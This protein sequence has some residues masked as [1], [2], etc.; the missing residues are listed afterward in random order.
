M[1][2]STAAD[3]EKEVNSRPLKTYY[4]IQDDK[5][6]N[7]Y[8]ISHVIYINSHC[9]WEEYEGTKFNGRP[10]WLVIYASGNTN[11]RVWE[12]RHSPP[13]GPSVVVT[14]FSEVRMKNFKISFIFLEPRA[15]FRKFSAGWL[16]L[17]SNFLRRPRVRLPTPSRRM[18]KARN[19]IDYKR[20]PRPFSILRRIIRWG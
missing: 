13:L 17:D 8:N 7:I 9:S 12:W 6:Y 14:T 5:S 2:S 19:K 16:E 10:V 3:S 18:G 1:S 4:S 20:A 15:Q 11:L